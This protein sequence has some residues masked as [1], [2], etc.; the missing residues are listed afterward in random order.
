MKTLLKFASITIIALIVDIS[1]IAQ[2]ITIEPNKETIKGKI[3]LNGRLFINSTT[4]FPLPTNSYLKYGN[5]LSISDDS[6]SSD[7]DLVLF[8]DSG[9][10]P[11]LNF[12]KARGTKI[13]PASVQSDDDL[14]QIRGLAYNQDDFYDAGGIQLFVDGT[15]TATSLPTGMRISTTSEGNTIPL[16]AISVRGTGKVG[17]GLEEPQ[18]QLSVVKG[19]NIDQNNE[20]GGTIDNGLKFGFNSGEGIASRRTGGDDSNYHGLD[21]YTNFNSRMT[22]TNYGLVG[23]GTTNPTQAKLVVN[24]NVNGSI[25][26]FAFFRNAS[27]LT[28]TNTTGNSFNYSIYASHRIAATE[29]NAFSDAR[30]KDI[31]EISNNEKDLET[32]SKIEITDYQ[33]KDKI[34]K[35]NGHYKKVIAQQVESVYPQAISKLTDC[36]PDIYQLTS[37]END[38]ISLPNHTLKVG[39]KVKLIF[40]TTQELVEVKEVNEKGFKI[41]NPESSIVNQQV[42]V[43]GREVSDF[44]SVDY[45][46]LSTLNI[47]ATQALLK[48]LNEAESRI[49]K[50]EKTQSE[51]L[52]QISQMSAQNKFPE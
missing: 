28:G 50:L 13:T 21:F 42:F 19:M 5:I 45:E 18:E 4:E 35:G 2:S 11:W 46:A 29:F 25:G 3:Q 43:Y 27:P 31:K 22:I 24:G 16:T 34:G 10:S 37:I 36:I 7:I 51:I 47:S 12:G 41:V 1:V 32:L 26:N 30:I 48:R 20:N 9:F 39:E 38:F 8:E 15:P 44:R 23:I 52:Q 6:D 49:N 17:I 33:F 14:I 40:V